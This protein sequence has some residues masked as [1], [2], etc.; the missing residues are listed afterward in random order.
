MSIAVFSL[1]IAWAASTLFALQLVPA[2][3][4]YNSIGAV[5]FVGGHLLAFGGSIIASISGISTIVRDREDCSWSDLSLIA[6]AIIV[7][8]FFSYYSFIRDSVVY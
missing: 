1:A 3:K 5:T 2:V 8:A 6:A 4:P 7:C